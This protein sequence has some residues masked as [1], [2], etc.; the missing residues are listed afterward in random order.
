MFARAEASV[1]CKKPFGTQA[2]SDVRGGVWIPLENH[3]DWS[4][5]ALSL[6]LPFPSYPANNTR[7]DNGWVLMMVYGFGGI[8]RWI[9]EFPG[10]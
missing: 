2:S 1:T 8:F 5:S 6:S 3:V 4:K 10:K 9:R 7:V